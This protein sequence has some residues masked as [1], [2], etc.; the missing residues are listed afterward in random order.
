MKKPGYA[1][2]GPALAEI[3]T[4]GM[5]NITSVTALI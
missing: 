5:G 4:I 3:D 1:W 2:A